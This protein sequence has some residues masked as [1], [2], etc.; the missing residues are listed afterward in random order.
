MRQYIGPQGVRR[1]L[2]CCYLGGFRSDGLL[3]RFGLMLHRPR[4]DVGDT[5]G[6]T[7]KAGFYTGSG[8][9]S[10]DQIPFSARIKWWRDPECEEPRQRTTW[11]S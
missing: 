2:Y 10:A 7:L 5:E 11:L 9:R 4:I 8:W 6:L 1:V 3:R